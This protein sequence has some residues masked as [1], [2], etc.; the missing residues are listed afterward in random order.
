MGRLTPCLCLLTVRNTATSLAMK[1]RSENGFCCG[2]VVVVVVV[3]VIVGDAPSGDGH[4]SKQDQ[5]WGQIPSDGGASE[6][7]DRGSWGPGADSL[8]SFEERDPLP[9]RASRTSLPPALGGKRR[10]HVPAHH[11]ASIQERRMGQGVMPLV[12]RGS[13]SLTA[14]RAIA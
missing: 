9:R 8:H 2:V 7:R 4:M 14:G 6:G 10:E 13:F 12:W 5:S 1:Q 11:Q 3:V